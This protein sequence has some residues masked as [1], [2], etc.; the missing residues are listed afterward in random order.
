MGFFS[1]SREDIEA[2]LAGKKARLAYLLKTID[3]ITSGI[4]GAMIE[5]ALDLTEGIASLEYQLG[6]MK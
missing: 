6:R 3:S 2:R 1:D 4:P 5:E